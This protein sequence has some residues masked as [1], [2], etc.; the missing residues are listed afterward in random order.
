MRPLALLF[1][2]SL[3]CLTGC[4]AEEC[5]NCEPPCERPPT[6]FVTPVPGLLLAGKPSVV[7]L[8]NVR[9]GQC[10]G[11]AVRERST[12]TAEVTDPVGVLIAKETFDPRLDLLHF[13]FT[14]QRPGPHHFVATFEPPGALLQFDLDAAIDRSAEPPAATYTGSCTTVEQ[15]SGGAWVCDSLFYRGETLVEDFA[16]YRLA[17]AQDVLW[18]VN[19]QEVRRYVD[20]GSA[21]V[22]TG[23]LMH[24]QG[25]VEFLLPSRDELLVLHDST[26]VRYSASSGELQASAPA[27]LIRSLD[28]LGDASGPAGLL[29]RDADHVAVVTTGPSPR[30]SLQV[31]AYRLT[32]SGPVPIAQKCQVVLGSLAGFEPHVLWLKLDTENSSQFTLH[33]W[34]WG[35]TGLMEQSSIG[36]SFRLQLV[37]RSFPRSTSVV[38]VVRSLSI[39]FPEV[40]SLHAVVAWSPQWRS[41]VLE[42]MDAELTAPA[43]SASHYWG[44]LP[45]STQS[46]ML[47]VRSR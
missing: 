19:H 47:R 28:R 31:C 37:T 11:V 15:L 39:S 12:V 22:L 32:A 34:L 24:G 25:A 3:L 36:M 33:R 6:P 16:E 8:Q 38:P 2:L 23:S 46:P 42:H 40:P 1:C 26:L 14:L 7:Q 45:S 27:P 41:L 9:L 21:L 44:P 18:A 10:G 4:P 43:A 35:A 20:T 5:I 17:V 13:G 30:Y 29:L